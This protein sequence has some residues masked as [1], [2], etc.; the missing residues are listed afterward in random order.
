MHC[1]LWGI[2]ENSVKAVLGFYEAHALIGEELL[3]LEHRLGTCS[4]EL[5]SVHSVTM[6][7]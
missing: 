4:T 6:D 7:A 2:Y 5:C 3:K 1:F